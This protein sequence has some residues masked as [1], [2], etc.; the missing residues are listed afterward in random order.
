MLAWTSAPMPVGPGI[1][2]YSGRRS[3]GPAGQMLCK[4]RAPGPFRPCSCPSRP[5]VPRALLTTDSLHARLQLGDSPEPQQA[6]PR[7]LFS[8]SKSRCLPFARP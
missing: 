5:P 4:R 8:M 6:S 7:S 1:Q 3:R 2:A